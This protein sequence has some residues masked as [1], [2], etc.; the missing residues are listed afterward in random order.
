MH[1]YSMILIVLVPSSILLMMNFLIFLL[2]R[3]ST[4][5][6]Q[7]Q[8][9]SVSAITQ[10]ALHPSKHTQRFKLNRRDVSLLKQMVYMFLTFVGGWGPV[11]IFLNCDT[12]TATIPILL[13]ITVVLA[14]FSSLINIMNLFLS[15]HDIRQWFREQYRCC[16]PF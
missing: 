6:I 7:P 16:F 12:L 8:A 13:P 1:L 14:A 5:R 4:K 15:D 10:S 3:S 9:L 11:Y 2:A